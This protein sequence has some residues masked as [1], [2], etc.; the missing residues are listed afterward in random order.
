MADR[1]FEFTV[2]T[3]HD[4]V[5]QAPARSL[6]VLAE[7]GLV[8]VRPRTEPTVLAVEAGVVKVDREQGVQFVGSAGGLLMCDGHQATLLTPLAVTGENEQELAEQL[9]KVLQQ[10]STEMK[11]R[12][13]LSRLEGRILEEL[14]QERRIEAGQTGGS[15]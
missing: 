5:L 13:M 9:Q 4:V 15:P 8:G 14:R 2:R 11:A 7:T 3:P 12:T 1:S 6:R 10:P